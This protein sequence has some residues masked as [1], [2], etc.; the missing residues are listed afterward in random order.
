MELSYINTSGERL[1]LRQSRPFF[2]TRIDGTGR[3]MQTVNTFKAPD[4]DGAFFIS[5]ALDMRNITLEGTVVAASV[6]EAYALRKRFLRVF[7]PKQQGLLVYRGRQIACVVEEA[8]FPLLRERAPNFFISLLCPSPF[9][10]AMTDIGKSSPCGR[11]YSPFRWR[12]QAAGSCSPCA[13][14]AR[15]SRWTTSV[16]WPAAATSSSWRWAA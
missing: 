9:F 11:R 13:S 3:V 4:Q 16:M 12:Y 1:S 7:T 14:P 8:G 10:E 2:L 6:D 5:S 15:S